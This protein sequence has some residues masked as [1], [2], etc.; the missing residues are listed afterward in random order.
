M[1]LLFDFFPILLFFIAFKFYGIYY[2][3]AVAMIASIL[4][5]A[6]YWIKHRRFETLHIITLVCVI[7]LGGATLLFHNPL[8]IKWKPTVIYWAFA[9][10]FFCT[11]FIGKKPLIQRMM[12]EKL[13][14]PQGV[15]HRLNLSWV[16][17]FVVMGCVNIYVAYHFS[18][19]IWVDFKLFGTLGLTFL[20]VIL[21][22]F[23]MARHA[24][25]QPGKSDANKISDT[26]NHH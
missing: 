24:E 20:F 7:F 14:L 15:W 22:A 4:Q 3:T 25:A 13:V 1:K 23:Y 8:F 2:A 5:V 21:Q 26:H 11:H 9:V 17:F 12:E 19:N 6:G 18:T 16:I 10:A